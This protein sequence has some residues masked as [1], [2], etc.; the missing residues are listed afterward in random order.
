MRC[1]NATEAE[2]LHP[3]SGVVRVCLLCLN[4]RLHN[5][6]SFAKTSIANIV[7]NYCALCQACDLPYFLST[8]TFVASILR[9]V[10]QAFALGAVPN[11]PEETCLD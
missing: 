7:V 11:V 8:L 2:Q 1:Y 6:G 10:S 5:L 9:V 4:S 3:R